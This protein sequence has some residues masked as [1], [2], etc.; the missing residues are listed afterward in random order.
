MQVN[1]SVLAELGVGQSKTGP[2]NTSTQL[3]ERFMT[4]LITQIK[5]QDPLNPLDNAQVTSQ[6]AQLNMVGGI[7]RLNEKIEGLAD[8]FRAAQTLQATGLIGREVLVSG[9]TL[10]SNGEGGR[11]GAEL[12]EPVDALAVRILD[13]AGNPVEEIN[14]GPQPAGIQGLAWDGVGSDGR[15]LAA[16]NYRIEATATNAGREVPV[17]VLT[18]APVSAVTTQAEGI[19]IELPGIGPV[20]LDEVRQ[21]I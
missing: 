14:M 10:Q 8:G 4:L 18:S 3:Q 19:T 11:F 7:E 6:L 16:G 9:D 15:Q 2:A 13:L 1:D 17:T 20:S 12:G 5:N 21:V